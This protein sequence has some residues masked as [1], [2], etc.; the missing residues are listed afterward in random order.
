MSNDE[1]LAA[2]AIATWNAALE[3]ADKFFT[4][5]DAAALAV[6]IAP[7]RN[8]LIYLWGHLSAMHDR[9]IELLGVGERVHPELDAI[10]LSAPDRSTELPSAEV[11]RAWWAEVN[12]RLTEGIAKLSTSDWLQ[13]HTAV[14]EEDFAREPL[15]NKFSILLTRTNHLSYHIGQTSLARK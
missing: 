13:R 4:G 12:V 8:R 9:M 14:S 11:I 1:R 15:R 6:Q 7:E 3:R 2:G 10:F 5:L